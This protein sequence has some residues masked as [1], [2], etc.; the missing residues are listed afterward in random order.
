MA[1]QVGKDMLWKKGR[2]HRH[3]WRRRNPLFAAANRWNRRNETKREHRTLKIEDGR[4]RIE[5]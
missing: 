1:N 2:V 3:P 4:M 5:D